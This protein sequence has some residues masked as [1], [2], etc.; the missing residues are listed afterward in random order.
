MPERY[1][2]AMAC[3]LIQQV[4][5]AHDMGD[6]KLFV[7]R[8]KKLAKLLTGHA[9]ALVGQFQRAPENPK[10]AATLGDGIEAWLDCYQQSHRGLRIAET[11]ELEK[12]FELLKLLGFKKEQIV[13]AGNS[14][15]MLS[16]EHEASE[17]RLPAANLIQRAGSYRSIKR[18][19]LEKTHMPTLFVSTS[20]EIL[21][22]SA[23]TKQG[24][25]S[26]A[27][28][29]LHHLFFLVGGYP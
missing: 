22:D 9:V 6:N 19:P 11:D 23:R 17:F 26:L 28:T 8:K 10:V 29:K 2:T 7:E 14:P 20:S 5:I 3:Y 24:G 25:A 13:L 21:R 15:D 12:L 16:K 1:I 4:L 27:M 18:T